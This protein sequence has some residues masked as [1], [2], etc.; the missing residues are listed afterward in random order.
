MEEN[1]KSGDVLWQRRSPGGYC[2][3]IQVFKNYNEYR[4]W[5]EDE[6]FWTKNDWPVL[7]VLHPSEGLFD[8]PSYYYESCAFV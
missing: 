6:C 5:N 4:R 8:D 2:L 3:V 7:R 1:I